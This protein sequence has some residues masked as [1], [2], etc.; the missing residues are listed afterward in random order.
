MTFSSEAH[1][2]QEGPTSQHD[3]V[4]YQT[5]L[6]QLHEASQRSG[7]D[8]F[9]TGVDSLCDILDG[10]TV[11]VRRENLSANEI[12]RAEGV[13]GDLPRQQMINV[14]VLMR[15]SKDDLRRFFIASK[16]DLK[17]AAVRVVESAAW[18]G[19]TFPIDTHQCRIE[20]QSGQFF[21]QGNDLDGN[22]VFY[23]QSVLRGPWRN[24][25]D[26]SLSAILYR[27]EKCLDRVSLE[28]PD[29]KCTVIVLLGK[30]TSK[31]KKRKKESKGEESNSTSG[32][33]DSQDGSQEDEED[34]IA[35]S[36]VDGNSWNPFKMGV[37]PRSNP[38]ERYQAHY[39]VKMIE[40]LADVLS[41]N[42][43]DRL[44]KLL[45]VPGKGVPKTEIGGLNGVRKSMA[46]ATR[47]KIIQLSK[48]SELTDHVSKRELATVV[49]GT[50]EV[51][52]EAFE[53]K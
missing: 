43:P 29:V 40:R 36:T 1:S 17:E 30:P 52:A 26:A 4:G 12:L 38:D 8:P 3:M 44:K 21:Q 46:S 28:D 53:A 13:Q 2:E 11:P 47:A 45:L 33:A 48:A 42:Y 37:N 35:E 23:F 10:V 39:S 50:A 16:C 15:T 9:Q 49:G 20:L 24:D 5:R 34:T 25:V 31:K 14:P 27:L 41:S 18:R 32:E 22:P 19:V 6:R 7:S 51:R